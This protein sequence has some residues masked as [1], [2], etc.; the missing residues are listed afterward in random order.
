[1]SNERKHMV[2]TALVEE[3]VRSAQPVASRSLVERY[4]LGCSPATVRNELVA[5]EESGH[6]FQPHVSAGRIPTDA[7]YRAVVDGLAKASAWITGPERE[8]VHARM[9]VLQTEIQ[10]ILKGATQLLTRL[11]DQVAV[12][13]TPT[14]RHSRVLRIDLVPLHAR[15]ILVVLITDDGQVTKR[16]VEL[17]ASM[18]EDVVRKTERILNHALGGKA[19]DELEEIKIDVATAVGAEGM[20]R[21][22]DGLLEGLQEMDAETVYHKGTTALLGQPEFSDPSMVRGLVGF[23]EDGMILVKAFADVLEAGEI[24]VRIGSENEVVQLGGMSVIASVYGSDASKGVV[25][26]LGPTRMD[27]QRAIGAVRCVAEELSESMEG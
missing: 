27:Y 19:A 16:Q 17:D 8:A 18:E 13:L 4:D 12:V 20:L 24:L 3:Y 26:V 11:T 21:L 14:L 5:L 23:L 9:L 2:L 1:M 25:G 6:V 10:D 15:S 7:G 22:I